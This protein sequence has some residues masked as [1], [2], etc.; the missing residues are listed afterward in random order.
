MLKKAS[1]SLLLAWTLV[2]V[3]VRAQSNLGSIVGIVTDASESA[4]PNVSVNV[5]NVDTGQTRKFNTG[6][7]GNYEVTRL[8]PGH[9]TV[10]AEASGF[11]HFVH[12]NVFLFPGATMRVDV[13]LEVASVTQQTTVTAVAEGTPEIEVESASLNDLRDTRQYR[14]LPQNQSREPY[15]IL[16]SM[17]SLYT[18][19]TQNSSSAYKYSIAGARTGQYEFQMDGVAAPNN[20]T[21]DGSVSQSMEGTLEVKLQAVNNSAEYGEPGIFQLI[22]RSGSNQFHGTGYYLFD[23]SAMDARDFFDLQKP[24]L[25]DHNF[26]GS[27]TG[28]V[29]IPH[30]YNGHNRTFVMAAYDGHTSPSQGVR[31]DS[32]PSLAY[33]AGDFSGLKTSIKDPLSQ[34]PFPG[35][36]VPATRFSPVALAFQNL[37]YPLPNGGAPGSVVNN[38]TTTYPHSQKEN[39]G[40]VRLDQYIGNRNSFYVRVGK[41]QF[42]GNDLKTL[43]TIGQ[44]RDLR[45]FSTIVVADTH[46]FSPRLVNEFRF[47]RIWEYSAYI[48]G[49]T[50]GLDVINKTG[51]QGLAGLPD[52]WGFPNITLTG[53][54]ALSENN[55]NRSFYHNRNRE[56]TDSMTYIHGRHTI[57]YGIDVRH[58]YPDTNNIPNGLYGNFSFAGSFT[59]APYADF[60]LGIPTTSG[61]V[62]VTPPVTKYETDWFFF[63]QDDFRVSSRLTISAG[64]RYEYQQPLMET[65]QLIYN[66]DAQTGQLVV[67]DSKIGNVNALFNPTIPIVK[68]SSVGYPQSGFR[69]SDTNNFAPRLGF[70]YR[71]DQKNDFVVRG[72]YGIFIVNMP[73]GVLGTYEGGPFSPVSVSFSN[74]LVN[75]APLF[76]FPNAFPNYG[77]SASSAP[78]SVSGVN[79]NLRNPYVQQWNLTVEKELAHVGL[80][81]S[82]I[83]T[84][85]V[86]LLYGRN[87]NLPMPST[88][89]FSQSLRPYPLYGNITFQDN[90]GNNIYHGLQLEGVRRLGRNLTFNAAW[91]WSNNISDIE[92]TG[93]G[94]SSTTIEDPYSRTRERGREGYAVTHRVVGNFIYSLPFG[95]QQRFLSHAP[96]VLDGILGGWQLSTLGT[97]Q[98]GLWFTPMFSGADTTGTGVSSGRPNRIA[99]GSLPASQQSIYD[100]F[101]KTAFTI[102]TLGNYGN[103]GRGILEGPP[104]RVLHLGLSKDF[105]IAERVHVNFQAIAQNALNHPNFSLPNVTFNNA[106]GGLI[107]STVQNTSAGAE[108]NTQARAVQLRLRISF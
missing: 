99:N 44:T 5:T 2:G 101:D 61:H 1:L 92:D 46:I 39:M 86:D 74:Q 21:P 30:I 102:P 70:A 31:T 38:L 55:T 8:Q 37:F 35:N 107:S 50:R 19:Q 15:T 48:Y 103:S 42:P 94:V 24:H 57:K 7:T 51:L 52:D 28:P 23:N 108:N 87:I 78:P 17:P 89:P 82:Y 25:I 59:G 56:F 98:T 73:N 4:M 26:G 83:G 96:K 93:S 63:V 27:L 34:A 80:R 84:R 9:Y 36:L 68:A 100:W 16:A 6:A 64:L 90:G 104:L 54:S 65:N 81:A 85:G 20:N 18:A 13:R 58:Q 40:D 10:E 3:A 95:R 33:R 91:T 67:P 32:V 88:T 79:I 60:L 62:P 14:T 29:L 76:Q 11:R 53:F 106:A 69:N 105:R 45:T 41:R 22:S 75:G 97:L 71:L 12:E 72:G 66:F 43:P 77:A 47:G 49:S